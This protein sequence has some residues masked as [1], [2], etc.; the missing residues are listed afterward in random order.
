MNNL[1]SPTQC[2]PPPQSPNLPPQPAH[3]YNPQPSQPLRPPHFYTPA[4]NPAFNM[5]KQPQS[6]PLG[7]AVLPLMTAIQCTICPPMYSI[8]VYTMS[9][10]CLIVEDL[11]ALVKLATVA[12][13]RAE[14]EAQAK[15]GVGVEAVR[16]LE[17]HGGIFRERI[18]SNSPFL[19]MWISSLGYY[20]QVG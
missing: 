15:E 2:Q 16:E 14:V 9:D 1:S 10:A 8:N 7:A 12:G 20:K 11:A 4:A 3:Y 13:A 19:T 5:Y 18:T 6:A 17:N